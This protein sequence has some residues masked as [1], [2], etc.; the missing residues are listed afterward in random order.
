M[1]V[2]DEVLYGR[3]ALMG[4]KLCSLMITTPNHENDLCL[5]KCWEYL[6]QLLKSSQESLKLLSLDTRAAVMLIKF[7]IPLASV[8]TLMIDI[9]FSPNALL[10][11]NALKKLNF[12]KLFP[13]VTSV[14]VSDDLILVNEVNY[15]VDEAEDTVDGM[16][17][18]PGSMERV[19]DLDVTLLD[20]GPESLNF[21][22]ELF[23]HVRTLSMCISPSIS[24]ELVRSKW[25]SLVLITEENECV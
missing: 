10:V 22:A 5:E 15:Y 7:Q 13:Q 25:P 17:I 21:L 18:E 8:T 19:T 12:F 11:R 1:T 20:F 2:L 9:D 3:L 16:E 14:A 4:P 23:P 6:G 24:H